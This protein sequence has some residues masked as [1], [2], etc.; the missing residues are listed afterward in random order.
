[1]CDNRIAFLYVDL[2]ILLGFFFFFLPF[3]LRY[4]IRGD[5]E[6]WNEVLS[7]AGQNASIVSVKRLGK[8]KYHGEVSLVFPAGFSAIN[9]THSTS[10]SCCCGSL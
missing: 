3:S 5:D 1:M 6:E 10:L 7:K 2:K 8:L 9:N 4:I